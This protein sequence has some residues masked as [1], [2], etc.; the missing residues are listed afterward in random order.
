M[1]EP[2]GEHHEEALVQVLPPEQPLV[3]GALVHVEGEGEELRRDRLAAHLVHLELRA[4][5]PPLPPDL[6][7]PLRAEAAQEV[8]K[9]AVRPRRV[10]QLRRGGRIGGR[11]RVVVPVILQPGTVMEAGL[12]EDG[13]LLLRAEVHVHGRHLV[14][15]G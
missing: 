5:G 11:R 4:H 15:L 8:V 9:V 2:L 3:D 10:R 7:P 6:E 14:L 12:G 13:R 1:A